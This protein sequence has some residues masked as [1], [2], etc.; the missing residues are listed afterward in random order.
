LQWP[1]PIRL[2]LWRWK[3][4]RRVEG[5]LPSETWL[6]RA[7]DAQRQKENAWALLSSVRALRCV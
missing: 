7:T 3:W 6:C 5:A 2:I 1:Q 4:S